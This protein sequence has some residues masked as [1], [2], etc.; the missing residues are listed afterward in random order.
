MP[1]GQGHNSAL[2]VELPAGG[3]LHLETIEEVEVWE[4]LADK[5]TSE[6]HLS[7]TNDLVNLGVILTHNL[8]LFR[9]QQLLN[10]M[11]PE[12]DANNQPTGTYKKVQMKPA[13]R[14]ATQQVII[15]ASTE[16]RELEKAL[17]IDKKTREQG[18]SQTVPDYLTHLKKLGH[19]M[20]VHISKRLTEY[21]RVMMRVR[22]EIRILDNADVE[23]RA[24][25]NITPE[26]I[27]KGLRDDLVRLEEVDK[28]FAKNKQAVFLGKV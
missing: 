15:K 13:D 22:T 19:S 4:T 16:I 3:V 5:Y 14:A 18:G 20:G 17:G 23:D 7:K 28:Q 8:A 1:L 10:G 6:H 21:E 11:E 9:A 26:S 2:D 24:H 12:Y 27:I 25:H